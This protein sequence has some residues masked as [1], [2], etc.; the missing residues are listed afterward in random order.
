[1]IKLLKYPVAQRVPIAI[2]LSLLATIT[3]IL[4]SIVS[5]SIALLAD[6]ADSAIN[7]STITLAVYMFK[8]SKK[9][10]DA[11]HPYGH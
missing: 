5:G 6:G 8:K 3:K 11:D 10:P 1:M 4:G 2:L 7:M 9:K